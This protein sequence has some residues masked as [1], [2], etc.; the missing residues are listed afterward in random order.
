MDQMIVDEAPVVPLYYD[1]VVRFSPLEIE[2]LGSNP[3]NLLVLKR[4]YRKE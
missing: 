3:M 2:G 1:M 4:V